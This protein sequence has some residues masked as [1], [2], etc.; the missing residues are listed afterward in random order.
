MRHRLYAVQRQK[1]LP[2]KRAYWQ[3]IRIVAADELAIIL[4]IAL[5]AGM[6]AARRNSERQAPEG[7]DF[8]VVSAR[9]PIS[10]FP[11]N[12]KPTGEKLNCLLVNQR[13]EK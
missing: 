3:S 6:G 8:E 13:R 12:M 4:D 2:V 1:R 7:E 5:G 9:F 11:S 10:K